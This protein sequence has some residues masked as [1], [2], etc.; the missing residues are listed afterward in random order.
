MQTLELKISGMMCDACVSHVT[1]ALQSAP[2]VQSATVDLASGTA[3]VAGDN[4][5]T[6]TL[7]EAVEEEGYSATPGAQN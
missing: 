4:F 5:D 2:G 3:R 6:A 7:L 1:N